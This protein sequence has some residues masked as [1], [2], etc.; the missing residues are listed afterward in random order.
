METRNTAQTPEEIVRALRR[1]VSRIEGPDPRN[2]DNAPTIGSGLAEL[3]R[4]L[5][6]GGFRPGTLVEWLAARPGSGAGS[7]ALS[8]ARQAIVPNKALVVM[9][10]LGRFFPPAAAAWGIDSRRLILIR[11][12]DEAD[13]LWALEQALRSEAVGAVWAKIDRLESRDFRRLQL[14][15]ETGGGL[16]LLL[17]PAGVQGC[18][19]WSHT[20][21]LVEP[22][23]PRRLRVCVVRSRTAC[24][25]ATVEVTLDNVAEMVPAASMRPSGA[26]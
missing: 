14:A 8:T 12:A 4:I 2:S 7:L 23:P 3:D 24:A 25:G 6:G 21:L 26:A 10:R 22:I 19:S 17:R 13:E 20:Q 5:P 15:A 18:P 11:A 9:D 1:E 16:G